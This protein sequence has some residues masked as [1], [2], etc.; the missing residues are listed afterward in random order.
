MFKSTR[1]ISKG[2]SLSWAAL[3]TASPSVQ[4]E[5]MPTLPAGQRNGNGSHPANGNGNGNGHA[6]EAA[7]PICP[8]HGKAMKPSQRGGWYCPVKIAE[9][10]GAGHPVYCKQKA[11]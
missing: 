6:L 10:D 9:D 7:A 1:A 3:K 4:F 11:S 8:T 5:P 2:V